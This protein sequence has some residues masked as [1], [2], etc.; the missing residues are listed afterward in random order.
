LLLEQFKRDS[1]SQ[2]NYIN[3]LERRKGKI[4]NLYWEQA[5]LGDLV[6]VIRLGLLSDLK[7]IQDAGGFKALNW[8]NLRKLFGD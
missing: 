2:R 4:A 7:N 5:K 1:E 8:A 6:E 3:G